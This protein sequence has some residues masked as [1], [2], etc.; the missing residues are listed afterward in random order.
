MSR[1]VQRLIAAQKHQPVITVG[2]Y[3]PLAMT[4]AYRILLELQC[5]RRLIRINDLTDDELATD[6]GLDR[7]V[8]AEDYNRIGAVKE[9]RRRAALFARKHPEVDFEEPLRSNVAGLKKLLNLTHTET[10]VLGLTAMIHCDHLL[11]RCVELLGD[12]NE[13]KVVHALTVLLQLSEEEVQEALGDNSKLYNSGLLEPFSGTYRAELT[14]RLSFASNDLLEYLNK[15]VKRI[16]QL[17]SHSFSQAG[18]S[19][20]TPEDYPHLSQTIETAVSY[21]RSCRKKRQTGVNILIYGPPGTGKTQFCLMLAKLLE[22]PIYEIASSTRTGEPIDGGARLCALRSAQTV[23]KHSDSLIMLDEIEDIFH[24]D[25]R[26]G[27]RARKSWINRALET[28]ELPCI[29]LSND[30]SEL[31]NAYVRRFDLVIEAPNPDKAQRVKILR[32]LGAARLGEGALERLGEHEALAPAV[33]ERAYKVARLAHPRSVKKQAQTVTEL[34]DSTLKAQGHPL[35]AKKKA[36]GLPSV[37]SPEYI[38]SDV[39]MTGLLSGLKRCTDARICL[40]GLPGTG[41]T[42]FAHWLA[43]SLE[44]PLH[45]KRASDLLGMYVG[46]TE[47]NMA[48]AFKEAEEEGAILLLDEV[49]S[50]LQERGKAQRNWEVT[51]V[52]EMLT[53]MESFE[54]IFIASTNLMDNLDQAALRRFDLKVNF[55]AL[56]REQRLALYKRHLAELKLTDQAPARAMLVGL[57]NL[58]PGDFAAVT[59]QARFN[60]FASAEELVK[61][62]AAEVALKAGPKRAIG[63]VH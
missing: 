44:K 46:E 23:L 18:A 50:F 27:P 49:D 60:P 47:G 17:F 13:S 59:R 21:L 28:N 58:T 12:L 55:K 41:K 25:T 52:N 33:F 11:N 16:D 63:F 5:H 20:L 54:G 24:S 37:Y 4:W 10:M 43:E 22:Q 38:N 31:D 32:N 62:L 56:T 45:I 15:K 19:L 42:A 7:W 40:Y 2:N 61:A 34:I 36:S 51:S 14:G 57:E 26:H 3:G 6:L 53:Q 1:L 29:W 48:R 8:E 35:L 39:D 30:V 9:L